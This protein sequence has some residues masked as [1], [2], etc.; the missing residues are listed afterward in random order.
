MLYDGQ[1]DIV[2]K[3]DHVI[4]LSSFLALLSHRFLPWNYSVWFS[5][6]TWNGTYFSRLFWV[7]LLVKR[8]FLIRNIR[9]AG[10]CDSLLLTA[11][12]TYIRSV[13]LYASPCF[14]NAPSFFLN[15]LLRFERRIFRIIGCES[16]CST[17]PIF[18]RTLM[19]TFVSG[20]R[21][22]V[23]P[24]A[25]EIS[26]VAVG[27]MPA[28]FVPSERGLRGFLTL[29]WN[30]SLKLLSLLF[31]LFLHDILCNSLTD[32]CIVRK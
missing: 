12:K 16:T 18:C 32:S 3:R 27:R 20:F 11:Y 26:A 17:D 23:S 5:T 7:K 31:Y 6:Q 9:R 13:L 14:C 19:F 4:F 28:T 8:V 25:S 30:V 24:F 29:L 22:P 10:C 15:R 2:T 1:L 21:Q